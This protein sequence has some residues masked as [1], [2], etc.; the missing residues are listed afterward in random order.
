MS[1][2]SAQPAR[3]GIS[4]WQ[5]GL[6]LALLVVAMF[7]QVVFGLETFV[8]RDYGFFVYPVAY[9][10]KQCFWQGELPFWNPYNNCGIPFLAQW[11]TMALYPPSLLYL[12][13]PLNWSLSFFSLLH[14]W[15]AGLGMYFLA[16]RWTGNSLAAA[17][18]GSVFAFN[19]FTLNLLMWPSHM[20]TFSWMPWTVL[21]VETAWREGGRKI[22][23][24]ACVGALQMLAGGPETIFLTWIIIS[25]LWLQQI[26]VGETPRSRMLWYLPLLVLLVFALSA[27]QLLPFLDLVAHAQRET[28]YTDLRWS[29]PASG[30]ANFLVPMAFGS[31]VTE[32]IFFQHGQYWT[33]SYYL[34]IGSLWLA[35]L[36]AFCV[37]ERRARLIGFAATVAVFFALGDHTPVYP[38][39]RKLIPQLS[40]IT[41]PIKFVMVAIFAVPLLAAY[42]VTVLDHCRKQI[43]W[44]GAMLF[45]AIVGVIIW[46]Q[47]GAGQGDESQGALVNGLSRAVIWLITGI[48]FIFFTTRQE[49]RSLYILTL[50]LIL[51][52][53]LDVLTHEPRQN[54]TVSP[55]VYELNLARSSLA[56][57][58][59]PELGGSRAMLSPAAALE[60]T[61]FGV[62][63]PKENLLAKRIGYCANVNL[64]DAVP[65]VDGFFSLTPREFDNLLT[66]VYS[67]TNNDWSALE[68]FMG[69][70]QYTAST[71]VLGWVPRT[72]FMPLVTA[73]Q[74]PVFLD[75]T[76][77]LWTIARNDFDPVRTVLLPLK[78]QSLVAAT[79]QTSAP[80]RHSRFSN[81]AVDFDIDT[82]SPTLAVVAQTYYHNWRAEIDGKPAIVLRANDAFQSV[83]VPEG[84]HHIHFFYRDHAFEIGAIISLATWLGCLTAIIVLRRRHFA[85]AALNEASE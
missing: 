76:N 59:Q 65:K 16:R 45:V 49:V 79:N 18:A 77:A 13:F 6:L 57:N 50:S 48:L 9:F 8:A 30:V 28:G 33:S 63:D 81:H 4:P 78:D 24:A 35:V 39:V 5:F 14:L 25:A 52:S 69:V 27:A 12:L 72:N 37:G 56:M 61:R 62:R 1:A 71:N 53:W 36:A 20:A 32:G 74:R 44:I 23:L 51:V 85:V 17:F 10:Q 29:M 3:Y 68:K 83:P 38:L 40:F 70:S 75:D 21:A 46:T 11:N 41:Y 22:P 58:P 73:G 15:F 43:I 19:G 7:P 67:V 34:G 42:A 47:Y 55:S 2:T 80:I 54:P 64:L 26:I 66:T 31:T 82:P 60:M 84:S